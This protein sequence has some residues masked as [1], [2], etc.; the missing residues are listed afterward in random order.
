MPPVQ[1]HGHDESDEATLSIPLSALRLNSQ[2]C[3]GVVPVAAVNDLALP[4]PDGLY[5][6]IL[7]DVGFECGKL[8]CAHHGKDVG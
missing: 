6:A 7:C 8:L 2:F 3:T 1:I 5:K 4:S